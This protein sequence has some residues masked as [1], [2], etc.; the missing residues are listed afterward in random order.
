MV[1]GDRI[2]LEQQRS[3]GRILAATAELYRR[4]PL[5]FVILALAVVGPYELGVLAVTGYGPLRHS[6]ESPG[7]SWLLLLLRTSLITPL[8]S[9][10]HMQAVVTI[11]DG[12]RPRL[13]AVGARGLRVLP[14]V[15]AAEVM[16]NIGIFLGFIA[17][18]IPGVILL[19]RWAVVAQ[20]AALEDERWLDALRSS[21]RLTAGH[22]GH[23]VALLL[24]TGILGFALRVCS[25]VIPL[26]STSAPASVA[27]G[28]A[29]ETVIASLSAL[30]LALLYFDLRA[31]AA[32]APREAPR[33]HHHLRDLD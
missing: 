19:L 21:R 25:W 8:V 29:V 1:R 4:F 7:I 26:G 6:H 14:I 3:L 24:V 5:L 27:V 10:L 18:I 20:A 15:A 30:T 23:V 11:G 12:Q 32:H 9:A 17:L 28:I 31:R 16:A 22:Y 13:S 2:G 33:E